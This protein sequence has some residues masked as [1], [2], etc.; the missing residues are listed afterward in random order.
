MDE[1]YS[2]LANAIITLAVKDF[3]AAYRSYLKHPTEER[4]REAERQEHF[5]HTPWYETLTDL[6]GDYLVREIKR[7]EEAKHG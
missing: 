5:F 6:D 4:K 2:K 1:N 3:A 7:R